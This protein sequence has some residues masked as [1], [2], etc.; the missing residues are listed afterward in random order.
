M[1]PDPGWRSPW[2]ARSYLTWSNPGP[3]TIAFYDGKGRELSQ[4]REV[5]YMNAPRFT[6]LLQRALLEPHAP[7]AG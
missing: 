5:G 3:P 2:V 6:A 7:R 4:F 1:N